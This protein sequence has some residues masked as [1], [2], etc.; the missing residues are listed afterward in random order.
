VTTSL[1]IQISEA[2]K[3]AMRAQDKIRLGT[4]RLIA[5]AIKQVEVDERCEMDDALVLKILDKMVKQRRESIAQFSAA[6][7]DDL[8]NKETAELQIIQSFLPAPLTEAEIESLVKAAI[9]STQAKEPK[10]MGKVMAQIKPAIA[11]RADGAV[12]S[13]KIKALLTSV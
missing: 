11:G 3:D 13:A 5:A 9:A 12:V 6:N 2:I 1:K 8:V 10:D 4:L 7:R